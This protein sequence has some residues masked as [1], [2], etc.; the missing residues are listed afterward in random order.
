[1]DTDQS[2]WLEGQAKGQQGGVGGKF[3]LT[4][5]HPKNCVADV[6]D[7]CVNFGIGAS[8]HSPHQTF[9]AWTLKFKC[10]G[11][12]SRPTPTFI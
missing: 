4:A 11:V 9:G 7:F 2:R 12:G 3:N 1:M 10:L 6:T 5:L 8:G